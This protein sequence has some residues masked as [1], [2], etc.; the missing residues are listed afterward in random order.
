MMAARKNALLKAPRG[1][2]TAVIVW[3][4]VLPRLK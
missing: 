2:P 4:K 1:T 3:P